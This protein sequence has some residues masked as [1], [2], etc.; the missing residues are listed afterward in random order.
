MTNTTTQS[1]LNPKA[2]DLE[3]RGT[4]ESGLDL[5]NAMISGRAQAI[6]SGSASAEPCERPTTENSTTAKYDLS[7]K[8]DLLQCVDDAL[9]T[10]EADLKNG[11]SEGLKDYLK[12]FSK[13]HSYSFRNILLIYMQNPEATMIAGYRKWQDMD[14]QVRKGEKGL[15]ILA[16][17]TRKK[18]DEDGP[19]ELDSDQKAKRVVMGFRGASVFDVSQTDGEELPVLHNYSGDPA[20]NLDRLKRF[21]ADSKIELVMECVEGGALGVSEEGKIRVRPDLDPATTFAVLAHEVAHELLHK[22]ERR[23]DTTKAIRETEAEAVAYAVCSAVGLEP[24]KTSS[25]YIQLHQG[26]AEK[27]NSSLDF[28]RKAASEILGALE[29]KK[30]EKKK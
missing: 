2:V 23:A 9:E 19:Q 27:L 29:L 18:K 22:G 17:M 26:D 1:E 11:H 21:V 28:I 14:R 16:P 7:N 8:E 30:P 10:L 3:L 5:A 12:F 4:E 13:F 20:D 6:P 24:H 15:R 25:D